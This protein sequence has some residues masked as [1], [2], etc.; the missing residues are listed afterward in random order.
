MPGAIACA[1]AGVTAVRR[2]VTAIDSTSSAVTVV[3][4]FALVIALRPEIWAARKL[5]WNNFVPVGLQAR[6]AL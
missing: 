1:R 4:R 3:L 2:S 6:E 5:T